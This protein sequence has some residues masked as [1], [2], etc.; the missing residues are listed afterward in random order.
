MCQTKDTALHMIAE[1]CTACL[2]HNLMCAAARSTEMPISSSAS[3]PNISRRNVSTML[4][5][6]LKVLAAYHSP[7]AIRPSKTWMVARTVTLC[8]AASHTDVDVKKPNLGHNDTNEITRD[9]SDAV[10]VTAI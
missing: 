9:T 8:E 6:R 7:K 4:D 3:S 2:L 10:P 5:L 1:D